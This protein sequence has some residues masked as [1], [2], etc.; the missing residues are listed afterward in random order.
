M[1]L[2][3][4]AAAL[5]TLLKAATID[6]HDEILD[7]ASEA[8]K[9]SPK[10]A[11]LRGAQIV[12]LLKLDRFD[13]AL[14]VIETAG[15]DLQRTFLLERA[16]ALYKT[17]KLAEARECLRPAVSSNEIAAMHLDA[18]VAYRNEQFGEA[19]AIIA[20]L[21]SL[22]NENDEGHDLRINLSAICAQV[23][24]QGGELADPSLDEGEPD[25]FELAYN[26][27]C[28]SIA[29]GRLERG[30]RLLSLATRLCD[31]FDDLSDEEKQ[32]E[33]VPIL[34]QQAYAYSRLGMHKEA[35]DVYQSID[36]SLYVPWPHRR[37]TNPQSEANP[38]VA[39]NLTRNPLCCGESI[40]PFLHPTIQARFC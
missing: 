7:K 9:S 21:L 3:N 14:R 37:A 40:P 11:N 34:V 22:P 20:E 27:A 6:D 36:S 24:H 26:A 31:A 10:D 13:D 17:G 4:P 30:V 1:S 2:K 19:Y 33:M 25:T 28:I 32:V 29:R 16:Y 18:Q 38:S 12:A 5:N 35:S 23:I 8:L 39:G 15:P